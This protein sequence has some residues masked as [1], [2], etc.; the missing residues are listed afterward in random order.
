M[1][2]QHYEMHGIKNKTDMFIKSK[3]E[4]RSSTQQRHL[5]LN[6]FMI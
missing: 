5:I 3:L 4:V 1:L 2:G 6:L